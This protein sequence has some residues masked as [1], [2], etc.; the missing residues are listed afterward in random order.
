[1]GIAK[2]DA[3]Q[4]AAVV[5]GPVFPKEIQVCG[6]NGALEDALQVSP[7]AATTPAG[8]NLPNLVTTTPPL[9][10]HVKALAAYIAEQYRKGDVV[11]L[12][13]TQDG[14]SRQFLAALKTVLKQAKGDVEIAEVQDQESLESSVRLNG[15]NLVVVGT[16]NQYQL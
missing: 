5:V 13:N 15:A 16:A 7:L 12:Y 8:Y 1:P 2:L 11:V 9:T 14:A 4:Q 3:I 10:A 6:F